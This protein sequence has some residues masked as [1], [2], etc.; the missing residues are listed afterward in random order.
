MW[1][2]IARR[3]LVSIPVVF[4]V[5]L[6]T[7]SI[8]RLAPG[9]PVMM[10]LSNEDEQPDAET[11]ANL[12]RQLGLD[13]P[14][15]KQFWDWF[16]GVFTGN[17]GSSF[18]SGFEVSELIG[19]RLQPSISLAVLGLG[20]GVVV[21]VPLGVL[22]AWNANR[23]IDRGVMLFAVLGWSVPGFFLAYI[24]IFVF[25]VKLGLFPVVGYVPIS[26]GLFDFLRSL[27]LPAF[28]VAIA[29]MALVAR[30]TRSSMIEVLREDYIRTARSK[31][32]RERIVM[33]RHALKPA[34][35]PVVTI[36]GIAFAGVITGVV[37]TE[38]VYSIN[39]LGRQLV[40]AVIFR[41][42][43]VIQSTMML[44]AI[45]YVVVNLVVDVLY[46]YIDPRI[47]Y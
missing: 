26:E 30:M 16:A 10:L 24:L 45:S 25:A 35:I 20:L 47:R 40:D 19:P 22:A 46:V 4:F 32:L 38:T 9:D 41:D 36:V 12:E 43:P 14:L 17:M 11:I 21:G 33:V 34:S 23:L 42:F 8:M 31:G 29:I 27:A 6:I 2:Y 37:V 5:A 15:P 44:V 28:S 13:K 7:F 39:G 3:I 1:R 18:R